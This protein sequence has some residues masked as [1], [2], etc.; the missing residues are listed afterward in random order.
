MMTFHS[1]S[2][3]VYDHFYGRILLKDLLHGH[4]GIIISAAAVQHPIH[5]IIYPFIMNHLIAILILQ[6]FC[7][8]RSDTHNTCLLFSLYRIEKSFLGMGMVY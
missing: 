7:Q 8:I 6:K 4:S 2:V 5:Q 1:V 3:Q